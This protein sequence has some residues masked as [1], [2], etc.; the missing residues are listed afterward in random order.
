MRICLYTGSALPKLG[1]QEAVVDALA[2]QF[3]ALGHEP[4]V[5]APRPRSPLDRS[6]DLRLPYRVVRHPRFFSTRRFVSGYAYFLRRAHATLAFDI[7]HCHDVY[8]TGYIGALCKKQSGVPLVITSHGGDVRAN[9]V[10]MQK[11][12]IPQ[13]S[14]VALRAADAVISI[15]PFTEREYRRLWPG[16]ESIVTIPNG[17]DLSEYRVQVERPFG[18]DESISAGG[19]LLF[20]GRLVKRKGI[21]VLLKALAELP[22]AQRTMAVIAGE[23]DERQS[24]EELSVRL[25]L[26]DQVRFVGPVTGQSKFWLVQNARFTV[27]PSRDEES[28][29]L[30]VLESFAAGRAVIGSAVSGIRDL[31]REGETGLLVPADDALALA[32]GIRRLMENLELTRSLGEN[33]RRVSAD[34]SWENIARRHVGLYE[35]L[36]ADCGATVS[37]RGSATR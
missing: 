23:G 32:V 5:L 20:L 37:S 29:G 25:E 14:V 36:K 4:V 18:L 15:G 6:G 17:V 27:M 35:R 31:I 2:R 1:G 16:I 7:I 34:Y 19:Y 8:P 11:P 10:R 22:A 26:R 24:L 28:F 33:G 13:R 30:V 12:G 3:L 9:S 21:D